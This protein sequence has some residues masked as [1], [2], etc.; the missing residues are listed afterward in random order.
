MKNIVI[1]II[2]LGLLSGVSMAGEKFE[3]KNEK[4]KESYSVGYL[5]GEDLK[6]QLADVNREAL[7][8]GIED[9]LRGNESLMS[10]ADMRTIVSFLRQNARMAQQKTF[11]EQGVKNLAE[12]KAFLAENAKKKEVTTL[13]SGL[14]YRVLKEGPGKSPK[15]TDMVTVHYRGTFVDGKEFDSS[16]SRGKPA[17]FQLDKVIRGW[18]EGL[19]LMKE[20]AKF[21]FVIPPE[22]AYGDRGIGGRVAPNATLVFEVELISV[23]ET[24]K[25][26]NK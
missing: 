4:D 14:Q 13:P 11:Q 19:Q 12:G 24:K 8:R 22:L 3:L 17:T 2:I 23:G 1:T 20:G 18:T 26:I 15:A 16:H 9:A 25:E 21:Q 5:F 7:A 6:K 10:A